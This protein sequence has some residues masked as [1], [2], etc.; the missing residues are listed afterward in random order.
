MRLWLGGKGV[1]ARREVWDLSVTITEIDPIKALE[2]HL[3]GFNVTLFNVA[4]IMIS[5]YSRYNKGY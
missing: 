5:S 3:D 1:P 4:H 2:A